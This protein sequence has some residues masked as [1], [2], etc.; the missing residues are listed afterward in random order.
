METTQIKKRKLSFAIDT[1]KQEYRKAVKRLEFHE[2]QL[3]K[4]GTFVDCLGN[5]YTNK[6]FHEFHFAEEKRFDNI[7]ETLQQKLE[8]LTDKLFILNCE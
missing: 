3:S 2:I 6:G 4:S 1:A 5:K 8:T 7:A